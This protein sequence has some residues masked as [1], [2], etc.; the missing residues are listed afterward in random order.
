MSTI[1]YVSLTRKNI[2]YIDCYSF[3]DCRTFDTYPTNIIDLSDPAAWKNS[4]NNNLDTVDCAEIFVKLNDYIEKTKSKVVIILPQNEHI[5]L[6]YRDNLVQISRYLKRFN[7][8]LSESFTFIKQ[9]DIEIENSPSL[10]Q[11][12]NYEVS[13][14]FVFADKSKGSVF[15]KTNG[16]L[17]KCALLVRENIA[18]TTME[19]DSYTDFAHFLGRIP[20]VLK[21]P[22]PTWAENYYVLNDEYLFKHK[23]ELLLEIKKASDKISKLDKEILDNIE[24]KS[25]L[26]KTG[27]DLVEAVFPLIEKIYECDLSH[28]VDEKKADFIFTK[29]STTIVGE[30]KGVKS[31]VNR[32]HVAKAEAHKQEYIQEL[33]D[34]NTPYNE[35]NILCVLI[36]NYEL[37]RPITERNDIN[38]EVIEYAKHQNV[39]IIDTATLI[40][41]YERKVSGEDP[42]RLI[43]ELIEKMPTGIYKIKV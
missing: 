41:L 11:L 29:N 43:K 12:S 4:Y 28:F 16:S 2:E 7:E 17:R 18:I 27:V 24:I 5:T 21:E 15:F 10:V 19:L 1:Q 22:T 42:S 8:L 33:E 26:W 37:D 13:S 3:R 20:N 38:P 23:T 25:C 30:I 14:D 34:S 35:E 32:T 31:N 9:N 39:L 36:I 40:K 6:G